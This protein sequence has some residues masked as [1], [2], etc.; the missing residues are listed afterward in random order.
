[1]TSHAASEYTCALPPTEGYDA[2]YEWPGEAEEGEIVNPGPSSAYVPSEYSAEESA[3][4]LHEG[5]TSTSFL[6][7]VVLQSTCLPSKRRL[8]ILTGYPEVQLGRDRPAAGSVTPRIRLK[9]MEV[10][11]FHATVYW[12]GAKQ[13]WGIVDMG[14]MHGTFVHAGSSPGSEPSNL[15]RLS[16]PRVASLPRRLRHLDT[17]SI[18]STVFS[19]H[20][21]D[22]NLACDA[23]ASS[24]VNEIPLFSTD[25][26]KPVAGVTKNMPPPTSVQ[27][28]DAKK[29]LSMLKQSLLRQH[30]SSSNCGPSRSSSYVDRAARRREMHGALS[31]GAPGT[32]GSQQTQSLSI[33]AAPTSGRNAST[34]VRNCNQSSTGPPKDLVS[35]PPAPL[36]ESNVG[37]RLL[38]KMGW[39]PGTGLGIISPDTDDV[40]GIVNPIE[41]NHHDKRAGLGTKRPAASLEENWREGERQKRYDSLRATLYEGR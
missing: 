28:K 15:T 16:Q 1:M 2:E 3:D 31:E 22:G 39:E 36:S 23:C 37:H 26:T 9:E 34:S 7:L 13:E 19:V 25:P 40:G 4:Q 32:W 18:G 11:K 10:S 35:D 21:H 5:T 14:S 27:S 20:I 24:A 6:R 33:E 38:S 29:S 12:D 41:V 8:A 17:L 30:T